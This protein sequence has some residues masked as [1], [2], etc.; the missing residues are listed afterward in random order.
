MT[1]PN[2]PRPETG[3]L[4]T[5]RKPESVRRS[6]DDTE[7]VSAINTDSVDRHGT[8]IS[9]EG[10]EVDS[11]VD[12]S[13][14]TGVFLINHNHDTPGGRSTVSLEKGK[15]LSR[16]KDDQWSGNPVAQEWKKM[17]VEEKTVRMTS[18]GILPL[19]VKEEEI[20]QKDA[21]PIRVPVISRSE[22][23]EWS[24]VSVGSNPD[25]LVQQRAMTDDLL[26]RLEGLHQKLDRILSGEIRMS[27]AQ[28]DALIEAVVQP[29]AVKATA[30]S[31]PQ[32]IAD[33]WDEHRIVGLVT[34][35]V[36][37]KLGKS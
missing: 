9:P 13:D 36:N 3:R 17:V 19:E 6:S 20:E 14:G 24:F 35:T 30:P 15:W 1:L 33:R 28:V 11:Y 12:K 22:L 21:D 27:D 5:F 10:M 31:K 4:F 34:R 23:L 16:V 25:A 18:V 26:A 8:I 32:P 2:I 37:E 29:P 7:T